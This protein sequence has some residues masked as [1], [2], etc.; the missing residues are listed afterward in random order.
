[1]W[2]QRCAAKT[3]ARNGAASCNGMNVESVAHEGIELAEFLRKHLHHRKIIAFGHSWGTMIGVTMIHERP[4]L[5]SAYVGTGQVMSIAEKEP[6]IYARTMARLRASH[7][8]GAIA[9]LKTVHPPYH[10]LDEIEVERDLSDAYDIPSERDL[11]NNLTAT[12]LYAPDWSV[13]DLYWFLNS[14]G[15][16][17]NATIDEVNYFDA[18]ALGPEFK[19]PFFIFNGAEDNITPTDHSRRYFDFV[20]APHKEFVSFPN[21]GHSAVLTMPDAFLQELVTRVR[22]IAIQNEKGAIHG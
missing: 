21:A 20:R 4:D 13:V 8:D 15:Y 1:M 9:K 19:V 3:F 16:A 6:V 2:D 12:V 14:G 22:P 18:R 10:S 17:E 11:R 5:F 7:A